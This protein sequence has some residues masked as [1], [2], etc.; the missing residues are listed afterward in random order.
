MNIYVGNVARTVT[1]EML[2]NLFSQFGEVSSVKLIKDK[3]TGATRGFAFV[4]MTSAEEAQQAIEQLNGH[5]LEGQQLRVNEARPMEQRPR[6]FDN[7][8][9]GMGGGNRSGGGFG[10]RPR[11]S[12]SN[13][14]GNGGGWNR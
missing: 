7:R 11:S 4:E 3:F 10:G 13:G 6:R 14:G 9:G 8:G 2:K 1:E 5:S 12:Y